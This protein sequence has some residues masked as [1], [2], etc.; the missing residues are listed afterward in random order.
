MI[1]CH[2][3]DC[4]AGDALPAHLQGI[5]GAYQTTFIVPGWAGATIPRSKAMSLPTFD[6]PGLREACRVRC[7]DFGDPACFEMNGSGPVDAPY[8]NKPC[9]E[10]MRDTGHEPGDE[11]DESAAVG[12]LL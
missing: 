8:C 12:R 6:D 1:R 2:C 7:A 4:R 10:C 11:F 9:A 5:P 3:R